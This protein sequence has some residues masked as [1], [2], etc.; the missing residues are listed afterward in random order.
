MTKA[1]LQPNEFIVHILEVDGRVSMVLKNPHEHPDVQALT[2]AHA[3]VATCKKLKRR[4]PKEISDIETK[5]VE[6]D[7]STQRDI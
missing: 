6:D 2:A 5:T 7:S 1:E 3:M 4:V